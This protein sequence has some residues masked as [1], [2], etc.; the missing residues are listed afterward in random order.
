MYE[1]YFTIM[2]RISGSFERL[3]TCACYRLNYKLDS[4]ENMIKF[5]KG[6]EEEGY[7]HALILFYKQLNE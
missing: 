4:M 3:Y 7:K 5:M 1:Y 2:Y 6:L